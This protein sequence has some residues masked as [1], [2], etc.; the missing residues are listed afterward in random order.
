MMKMIQTILVTGATGTVG[1]QVVRQL[2]TA[3]INISIRVGG[4]SVE[5]VRRVVNSDQ[6]EPVQIDYYKPETI[7]EAVKNVDSVFL[8]KLYNSFI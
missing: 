1:N 6:V 5:N 3:S 8:V 2:S 4:R 7:S